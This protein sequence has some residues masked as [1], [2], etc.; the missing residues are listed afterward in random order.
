ML[1][2][3][4]HSETLSFLVCICFVFE[5]SKQNVSR[6]LSTVKGNLT[7][8]EITRYHGMYRQTIFPLNRR[9]HRTGSSAFIQR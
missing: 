1:H 6:H 4:S 5:I 3:R 7:T 9:R 2:V 8:I